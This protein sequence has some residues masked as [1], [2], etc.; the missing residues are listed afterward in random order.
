MWPVSTPATTD[1]VRDATFDSNGHLTD[2]SGNVSNFITH[3]LAYRTKSPDSGVLFAL[4]P[5][6]CPPTSSIQWHNF[7][8]E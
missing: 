6:G 2:F 1:L 4:I 7:G 8:L 5:T 3:L